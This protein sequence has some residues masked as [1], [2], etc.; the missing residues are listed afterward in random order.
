[1]TRSSKIVGVTGNLANKESCIV[2]LINNTSGSFIFAGCNEN[3]LEVS[4]SVNGNSSKDVTVLKD[5]IALIDA[6][7]STQAIDSGS[8]V[9]RFFYEVQGRYFTNYISVYWIYGDGTIT[10]AQ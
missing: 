10:I 1:M 8:C 6:V 4:E 7:N 3:G 5:S 2:H 9:R